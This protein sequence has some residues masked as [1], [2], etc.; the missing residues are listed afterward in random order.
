MNE[1]NASVAPWEDDFAQSGEIA[2]ERSVSETA[3]EPIS[4]EKAMLADEI[5]SEF[6]GFW[7][8]LVSQTNWEKGRVINT[9]R[10]KLLDAQLPRSLWSDESI[11]RR[12][13]NVSS[14]HVGRLR[15]VFERFGDAVVYRE[16]DRFANLYWSHY[17]A[18][19]DW[20]DAEEWL[21]KA[22]NESLSVALMRI[23]R[24]EKYGAPASKKPKPEEIVAAE[25]DEDVNPMNDSDADLIDIGSLSDDWADDSRQTEKKK[26]SNAN[27]AADADEQT[28]D[29]SGDAEIEA[30][31][32]RTR[33]SD[34][35]WTPPIRTTDDV[36]RTF[37][38]LPK[39]PDA[40]ADP[41]NGVKMAILDQRLAGWDAETQ[42]AAVVW[43][44]RLAELAAAQDDEK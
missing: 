34:E 29:Y 38:E 40:L 30:E 32:G 9:W 1:L 19:L 28:F 42:V 14:Q 35:V 20:D 21:E 41:M 37:S 25:P 18:A 31:L 10:T 16:N 22:S 36:L 13:G 17:Q 2:P 33:G 44:R 5:A 7:N 39:L 3:D 27:D 26:K 4:P 43:L 15:R 11:S 6:I 8:R 12:I 23:A 24:W